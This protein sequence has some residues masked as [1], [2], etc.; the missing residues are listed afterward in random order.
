[1]RNFRAF[2][3]SRNRTLQEPTHCGS[4]NH[5]RRI[6]DGRAGRFGAGSEERDGC[7][8]LALDG[9]LVAVDIDAVDQEA[10]IVL[11]ERLVCTEK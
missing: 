3:G 2:P 1:L 7:A 4:K 11:R 6:N 5:F 9:Q 10:Q 8:N